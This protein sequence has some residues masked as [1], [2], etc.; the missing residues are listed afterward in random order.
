MTALLALLAGT[1]ACTVTR[2][3]GEEPVSDDT[4]TP[5]A[6]DTAPTDSTETGDTALGCPLPVP[7]HVTL[8][9]SIRGSNHVP[10]YV[11]HAGWALATLHA[12]RHLEGLAAEQIDLRLSPSWFFAI[13][14]ESSFMGCSSAIAADP[15]DPAIQW[16]HQPDAVGDGCFALSDQAHLF[17]LCRLYPE[18]L[19]CTA[20]THQT[21]ISSALEETTGRDNVEPGVLATAWYALFSYAM[22]QWSSGANEADPDAWLAAAADPWAVEKL[23]ALAH[24]E[25]AYSSLVVL[26]VQ[27]CQD[28]AIEDCWA[29][30]APTRA[31]LAIGVAS[32][33]A[34]LEGGLAA[35]HC[36][37]RVL[38]DAEVS[39]YVQSLAVL[40]PDGDTEAATEA[41]LAALG[42]P[43]APFQAVGDDV[44][45]AID[46]AWPL[47]LRCPGSELSTRFTVGCPP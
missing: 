28:Q 25:T 2:W 17:D 26:S 20:T 47:R 14:L 41:A 4:G 7:D 43:E 38:T 12:S 1:G 5:D 40:F 37:D 9:A 8:S 39:D 36:Y 35:G 42:G 3:V 18:E 10:F 27:G 45:A 33:V 15:E 13:A 6:T 24:R 23:M 31:D 32:H 46:G 34:D 21:A 11:P 19:D 29:D 22:I 16:D 44:V 30:A